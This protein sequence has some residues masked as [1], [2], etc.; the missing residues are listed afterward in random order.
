MVT[1]ISICVHDRIEK[2]FTIARQ[3]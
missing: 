1:P 3:G 2:L